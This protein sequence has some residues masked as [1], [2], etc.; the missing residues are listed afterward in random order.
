[1]L[2]FIGVFLGIYA[3]MKAFCSGIYASDGDSVQAIGSF[4]LALIFFACAF[5][6]LFH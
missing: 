4:I 3:F 6:L 1:M 2:T 5:S